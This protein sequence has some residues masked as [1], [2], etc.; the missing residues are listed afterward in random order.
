MKTVTTQR[1]YSL[2][3]MLVS[4][5]LFSLVMLL[6]TGAFI[7]FM[8]LEK[9]A[10]YTNDVTNNLTFAVDSMARS[11]RTGTNYSC[12]GTAGVVNCWDDGQFGQDSF[13]FTD[14]QGRTITYVRRGDGAIGRCTHSDSSTCL[15]SLTDSVALTDKRISIESLNFFVR[16]IGPAG[17][18][19]PTA[20]KNTQP[21]VLISI[22][23]EMRPEPDKPP[24]RFTIQ[25]LATQRLLELSP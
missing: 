20:T 17:D 21:Q 5:G 19:Q 25:T 16:G 10:R 15:D 9:V 8:A 3:E 1:G 7:K 2:L 22:R 11:I 24:I 14:D 6:A 12:G 4:I 13:S 18:E 23:G